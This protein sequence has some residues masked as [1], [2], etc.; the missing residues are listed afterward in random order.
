VSEELR[1]KGYL[2]KSGHARGTLVGAYESFNLGATTFDQLRRAQIIPDRDYGKYQTRKP[3]GLVVDRRGDEPIVKFVIEYKDAGKLD[4][5]SKTHDFIDKVAEEYCRPLSCEFGGVSD[6]RRNSW[7]LVSPSSWKFIRREDDYPLDYPIDLASDAGRALIAK[8]LDRLETDLNKPQ[9]ALVPLEAV[10]PTRLAEQTWQDIW[11][12]CGQ[13]PEA[14]LA[15]F[16]E[17]LIFKFLSDL[18]VLRFDAAGVP[19]DFT[20]VFKKDTDKVLIYYYEQVRPAIKALFPAGTD[21][22]SIINGIVLDPKVQD[23]GRLFHQILQRFQDF[24]SLRRIDPEFKSRI[25][26]RFLK[27]NLSVKNWGQYFTPRNVVKAMVEMSGVEYLPPGAVLADPACGVGGF[28]LEP[29]MN[30]RPHD[31]RSATAPNLNYV[32]WDRD[33]KTII[34]AKANMLVHLSE[35]LENDPAGA[36]PRLAQVLNETFLSTSNSSTGSLAKAP[37]EVFDL[38]MTN[39]PYVTRG[40]GKHRDLLRQDQQLQEYYSIP[41]AGV[42]N[43]FVQL[44]INGLK[45]GARALVIVP[46]GLLLRHSEDTLRAHILRTCYLEAIVSLPKDTFYSTPKKTYILA[47]RKKQAPGDVQ[48]EAVFTYLITEVGE[49][50]DA[51]RFTITENDLPKMSSAFRLFQGN[52]QEFTSKDN[53]CKLF[54]IDRFKPDEHWLVNKWWPREEREQ[55]GDSDEESFVSPTELAPILKETGAMLDKHA[56]TLLISGRTK[57]VSRTV[58]LS[59]SDK[60]LFRMSIGKRV[61]KKTLFYAKPGPVPLYSANVEIGKEH[62]WIEQ[63]NLKDFSRP[64]LLWSIDSDFNMT[65]RMA[66]D[67]FATTDHCG[68]MEILSD[69]LDPVYCQAAIVY[70]FGRTYGFDRVTRPSLR[71]MAAVTFKVPVKTDG[72]FDLEAQRD[73]AREFSAIQDAVDDVKK[74]L[75]AVSDL[76]PRADLPK[77]AIDTGF[78]GEQIKPQ[79]LDEQ[80]FHSL[81]KK[82]RKDTQHLSSVAKMTQHPAYRRIIGMGFDV[83]P[84]LFAELRRHP[85]HWLVALNAITGEDPV[86]STSTFEQAVKAWLT[87]GKEKGYLK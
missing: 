42:E 74:G 49:T 35:V 84:Y 7:V 56:E 48:R 37:R 63:S 3:D 79:P 77:D 70:G 1:Q 31:F 75:E 43:L 62:G 27:K 83:L 24:G 87:W 26:E 21:D 14:C 57:Q 46:D 2:D 40:T 71:R 23:Q 25:F 47:I 61:L 17:I 38:V 52:P 67:V 51:K 29:L 9:A 86:P 22:T 65:S 32:G 81:V 69:D 54:P 45:P 44:I 85:D 59:L 12:A 78:R 15:T 28:V 76:K 20:T 50:R 10:N 36:I 39:P 72:T 34:L 5:E 6:Q 53:R 33:D 8:T 80:E 4:S 11:L 18:N 55:L 16:I 82:W 66:G 41:G 13:Q 58:T 68:R 73:L 19:V 64:S 30:K 60:T